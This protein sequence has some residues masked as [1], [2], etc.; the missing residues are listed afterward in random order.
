MSGSGVSVF[1]EPDDFVSALAATGSAGLLVVGR[2]AFHARMTRITLAHLRLSSVE[3]RLA[4]I[5]FVA[6][7]PGTVRVYLPLRSSPPFPVYGG[8]PVEAGTIVIHAAGKWR[9]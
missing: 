5:A 7:P 1:S 8:M 9:V 4:R 2:G 3:E 6:P